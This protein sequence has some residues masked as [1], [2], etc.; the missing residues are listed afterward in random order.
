MS[1]AMPTPEELEPLPAWRS[2]GSRC[3]RRRLLFFY[4]LASETLGF[5]VTIGDHGADG[6]SS[7]SAPSRS[8]RCRWPMIAPFMRST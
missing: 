1:S 8:L 5:L 2:T 7:P 6:Q 4:A 3:F